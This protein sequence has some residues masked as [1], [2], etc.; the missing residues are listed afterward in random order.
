VQKDI[1]TLIFLLLCAVFSQ[2]NLAADKPIDS[3]S[4]IGAEVTTALAESDRVTVVVMLQSPSASLSDGVAQFRNSIAQS[5]DETLAALPVDSYTLRRRF[6]NVS[7][8]T[9]DISAAALSTLNNRENVVRIDVDVGGGAQ[10]LQAAPL[11]HVSDV[12]TQGFTGKGIKTAVIDSGAQLDHPDLADSIVGQQCYCS[13]ATPGVGC[14]PSGADTQSGVGSGEDGEGHG[15]NV[16]GIITGNGTHAP[17]GGAPDAS[18]V[19]VRVLDSQGR[20][21]DTSDIV[22]AL[23]WIATNHPTTKVVNMSVGTDLL[24][25]AACDN[26]QSWTMA[27]KQAVNAVTAHG[28]MLTSSSGNQA[29]ATG[30]SAPAC[31]SGVIAVGAVWDSNLGS[32]TFLGCTD[33]TTAADKPTCFTNSNALVELYAPGAYTTATGAAIDP[34]TINFAS[35]YGGTSQAAPLVASCIADLFQLK[36]TSTAAQIN[37]ALVSSTTHVTDPKSGISFPRLNCEQALIYIDRIF[38]NG[39]QPSS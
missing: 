1:R 11:A 22:A 37:S 13:S 9:L 4:K 29:S 16:T 5:V 35:T 32:Q 10:L 30:I 12:R 8:I 25:S 7:A 34:F 39:F 33:S 26:S 18:V 20:F 38:A 21:Q 14:C 6:D 23:D 24:F 36:P 3:S 15:T 19:I 27:L 17:Q 2:S 31:I 28:T